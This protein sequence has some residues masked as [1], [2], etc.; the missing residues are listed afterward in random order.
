MLLYFPM[1]IAVFMTVTRDLL[2]A[3][4]IN[5]FDWQTYI[6]PGLCLNFFALCIR[7]GRGDPLSLPVM[8][9]QYFATPCKGAPSAH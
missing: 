2:S 6:S 1:V 4:Q 7:C 5:C 3:L 8:V 9:G